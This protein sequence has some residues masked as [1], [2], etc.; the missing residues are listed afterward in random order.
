MRIAVLSGK[1]GTGK[2]FVSVN[3][4]AA[5]RVAAYIDCDAEEPDGHLFFKPENT[6]E[7]KVYSMIPVI[8]PDAC[9]GCRQCVDFCR[10]NALA[11]VQGKPKVFAEV[12]HACGG[13]A[14]VCP[15][16]AITEERR[17]IGRVVSGVSDGIPVI[18]SMLNPGE[19]SA[20]PV[21]KAALRIGA[22]P[23]AVIDS[24]PG[25]GCPVMETVSAADYCLIVAEPTAFGFHNFRM[26]HR[27]VTLLHK[28]FGVIVN[29]ADSAYPPL[30]AYCKTH[31]APILTRILYSTKLAEIG[32]RGDIA[33]RRSAELAQLFKGLWDTIRAE[34]AI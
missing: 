19:A 21:I 33:A 10:F 11:F 30:E 12:C 13:C 24:P 25:S 26:V 5:A 28:P 1:G 31:H 18:T 2:T 17:E 16:G 29:K 9:D 14:L 23:D 15:N 27:L 20:V 32:A 6:L 8:H 7:T 3:L 4:A 22:Y 34:A